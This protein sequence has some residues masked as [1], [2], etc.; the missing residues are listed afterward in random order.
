MIPKIIHQ[1]APTKH[2]SW[3]ERRMS[4][5]MRSILKDWEYAL[6]DDF[7]ND[8]LV[9]QYFPQFV[10]PYRGIERGVVRAD[11]ARC[12]YLYVHGGFYF[13]TDYKILAPIGDDILAN[14][15]VLPI[16]RGSVDQLSSLRLGNAVMGSSPR[17]PFWEDFLNDLFSSGT[18]HNLSEDKIE[19][20]TGPEGLTYFFV[21]NVHK[22]LDVALPPR[23][24]FHPML[25]AGN[26]SY[27]ARSETLGAHLCWGSWRTKH[28]PR[29][30]RN[31]CTRKITAL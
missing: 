4:A 5:R 14:S 2:L 9:A 31:I 1:T 24:V 15:C 29:L 3:E 11:I 12:M 30:A 25:T 8:R 10:E 19:K 22:Y 6:W 13:D 23:E 26:F 7:D 28:I 20:T 21:R 16:S 18:L 17:H 27:E